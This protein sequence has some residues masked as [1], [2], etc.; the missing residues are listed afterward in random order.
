[1]LLIGTKADPRTVPTHNNIPDNI[2]SSIKMI[3]LKIKKAEKHIE[4]LNFKARV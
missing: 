4:Q 2:I 3:I 1:L